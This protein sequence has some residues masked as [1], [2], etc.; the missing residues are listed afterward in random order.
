MSQD[1]PKISPKMAQD[2]PKM[3]QAEPKIAQDV[4]KRP[5]DEKVF[6]RNGVNIAILSFLKG[7]PRKITI[8]EGPPTQNHHF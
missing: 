2:E 3:A 7:L 1:G 6:L 4:P 5:Q 8:F